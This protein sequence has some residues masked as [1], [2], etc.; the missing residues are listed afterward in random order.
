LTIDDGVVFMFNVTDTNGT[1]WECGFMHRP[2]ET[3]TGN[4]P[5]PD[6]GSWVETLKYYS[7]NNKT[8]RI[9]L[10]DAVTVP[11]NSWWGEGITFYQVDVVTG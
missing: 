10:D 2:S 11:Y 3:P 8:V 5:V 9:V 4:P 7:R 6:L 1:L